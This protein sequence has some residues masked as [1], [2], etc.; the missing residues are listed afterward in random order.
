LSKT[1]RV[2]DLVKEISELESLRESKLAELQ[3]LIGD[4]SGPRAKAAKTAKAGT[5]WP[6]RIVQYLAR[7]RGQ[8]V[9]AG[10]LCKSL[11]CPPHVL[12]YHMKALIEE[13][14]VKRVKRGYYQLRG[15]S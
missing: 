12:V 13:K 2:V 6:E 4:K 3:A 14:R 7:R 8:A 15:R 11:K 5:E 9:G 1:Q 10:E